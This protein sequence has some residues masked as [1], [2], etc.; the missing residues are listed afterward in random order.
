MVETE[1]RGARTQNI[2]GLT[3]LKAEVALPIVLLGTD[4]IFGALALAAFTAV[5]NQLLE[6]RLLAEVALQRKLLLCVRWTVGLAV[7]YACTLGV[8]GWP[9][10]YQ[11]SGQHHVDFQKALA[12]PKMAGSILLFVALLRTLAVFADRWLAKKGP[13]PKS[14]SE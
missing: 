4:S 12:V 7:V 13:Q 5:L 1:R 2:V 10:T 9:Y 14:A 3:L 8:I 6:L 11:S